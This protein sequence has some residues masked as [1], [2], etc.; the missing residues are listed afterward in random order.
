MIIK[1]R[2]NS[3]EELRNIVPD[4]GVEVDLRSSGND[5]ICSHDPFVEADSFYE[6]IEKYDHKF[7]IANIKSEGIEEEVF[8]ILNKKKIC[9]FFFLDVSFP[10]MCKLRSM[11]ITDFAYRVSDLEEFNVD[12]FEWLECS[13]IWLDAFL[14]FPDKEIKKINNIISSKKICLVSPELHMIRDKEI[15]KNILKKIN[16]SKL[17]FH[18]VCTKDPSQWI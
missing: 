6:W 1:H 9:N 11:G 14:Q 4:L 17:K 2:V 3:I 16:S 5:I 10:F 15:S 8:S 7:L 12:A 13:W 18:A